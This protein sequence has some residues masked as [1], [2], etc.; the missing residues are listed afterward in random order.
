VRR[1]NPYL[2]AIDLI[3]ISGLIGPTVFAVIIVIRPP[4]SVSVK[5]YV[6]FSIPSR[7]T[8][9]SDPTGGGLSIAFAILVNHP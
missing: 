8:A 5:T 7:V 2:L 3:G 1:P 4:P 6:S 9:A